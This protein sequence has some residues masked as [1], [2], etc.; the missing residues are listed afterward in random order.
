MN[1]FKINFHYVV[2]NCYS[3]FN[4]IQ[5]M[6]INNTIKEYGLL[7]ELLLTQILEHFK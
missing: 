3:F 1:V 4:I 7:V 6:K 2:T 5:N